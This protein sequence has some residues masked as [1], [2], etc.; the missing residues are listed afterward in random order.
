MKILLLL[1]L[2]CLC[3]MVMSSAAGPQAAGADTGLLIIDIQNFYF[4]GGKLPLTGPVEASAQA[5]ALLER[6][7]ALKKPVFHVQHLPAGKET[8]QPGTDDPQY[9]I[10]SSV[11]PM[12]GEKVIFKHDANSFRGTSLLS[13]LKAAGV[14]K[15]VICGMQ[16]HMCVEAAVRAAADF[17]FEVMLASDACA[18]RP[19]TFNGREVPAETVHATTLAV[20]NGSYAR[21]LPTAELLGM[22]K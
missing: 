1:A 8:Y 17:G 13:D 9:A 22:L 7:R 21:V 4:A 2:T 5:K 14:K 10:H 16:T 6:F 20:L 19:L 3:S 15:L 18:T 11:A 12:P